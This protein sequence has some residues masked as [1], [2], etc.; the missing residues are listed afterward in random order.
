MLLIPPG[1]LK[2]PRQVFLAGLCDHAVARVGALAS[3]SGLCGVG[4][5]LCCDPEL[6]T[7]RVLTVGDGGLAA[8]V[9][10]SECAA[11]GDERGVAV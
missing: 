8:L 5:S 11:H 2:E 9:G 7:R 3:R 6:T 4:G 1:E 10:L